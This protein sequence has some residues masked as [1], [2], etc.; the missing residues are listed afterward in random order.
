MQIEYIQQQIEYRLCNWFQ[1]ME[2]AWIYIILLY[3]CQ[4]VQT[5]FELRLVKINIVCKFWTATIKA[6]ECAQT[7]T[8][9]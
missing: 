3:K 2:I 8:L 7:Q 6:E 9:D 1:C 4:S 5:E